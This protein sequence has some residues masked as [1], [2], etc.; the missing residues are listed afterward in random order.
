MSRLDEDKR[1]GEWNC[2]RPLDSGG[3]GDVW[4]VVHKD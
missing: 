1:V 3:N 4:E 2:V